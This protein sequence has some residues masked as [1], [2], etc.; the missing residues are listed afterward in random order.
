MNLVY[1]YYLANINVKKQKTPHIKRLFPASSVATLY[2][3]F[4][5]TEISYA[6]IPYS[7]ILFS[8]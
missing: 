7:N 6:I 3:F 8:V 2:R 1:Q 5:F 4:D